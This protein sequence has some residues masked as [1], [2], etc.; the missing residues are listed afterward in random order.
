MRE[1]EIERERE[2]ERESKKRAR[3]RLLPKK[4]QEYLTIPEYLP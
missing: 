1:R 2:R 3:K 4:F